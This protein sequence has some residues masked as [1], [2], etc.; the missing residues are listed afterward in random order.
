MK[1]K[2]KSKKKV[3]RN[4]KGQIQPGQVLNPKGRPAVPEVQLLRDAINAVGKKKKKSFYALA[5]EKA[6]EDNSVLIALLRKL[7]PDLKV[8]EETVTSFEAS[9]S[10]ELA[11]AIQDKLIARHKS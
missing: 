10:N 3:Q 5:A 8:V 6:Y 11:K 2:K 9:M 7:V 4:N 1:G